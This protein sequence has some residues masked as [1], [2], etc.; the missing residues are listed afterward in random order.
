MNDIVN[1]FLLVRDKFMPEIHLKQ[2]GLTY[3]ACGPFSKNE[4]KI[5][6]FMQTEN[7]D[8]MYRN[9]VDKT[10]FQHEVTCDKSKDL[11]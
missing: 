8:S 1:T 10:C 3:S 5:E 4:E 11:V 6:K 9:G 2:P 7:T